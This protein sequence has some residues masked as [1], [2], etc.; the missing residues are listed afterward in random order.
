[1]DPKGGQMDLKG[2]QLNPKKK[3]L[4]TFIPISTQKSNPPH[5][6]INMEDC[7]P[8][9][10]PDEQY[11]PLPGSPSGSEDE[12]PDT[13]PELQADEL[14]KTYGRKQLYRSRSSSGCGNFDLCLVS[15][16]PKL[17][18]MC[19]DSEHTSTSIWDKCDIL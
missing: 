5:V 4:P 14:K 10:F 2:E 12:S 8:C 17:I 15:L 7:E 6:V 1:M 11:P 13:D 18:S 19:E 9:S 16:H 3:L